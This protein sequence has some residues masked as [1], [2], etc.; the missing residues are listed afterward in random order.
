MHFK[1][2]MH[3]FLLPY[4]SRKKTTKDAQP[5]EEQRVC[6]RTCCISEFR[7]SLEVEATSDSSQDFF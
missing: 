6:A 4:L 5:P 7:K 3:F 2:S 1:I